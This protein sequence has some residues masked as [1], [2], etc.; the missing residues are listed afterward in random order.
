MS[1][2]AA[3]GSGMD[4]SAGPDGGETARGGVLEGGEGLILLQPLGKV[5]GGLGIES[6][7][8]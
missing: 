1:A 2:G 3:N 6:I 5:L 7:L 4:A 8:A